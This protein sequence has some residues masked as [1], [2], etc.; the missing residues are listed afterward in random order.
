MWTLRSEISY[1]FKEKKIVEEGRGNKN[2]NSP[3]KQEKGNWGKT[4]SKSLEGDAPS[5]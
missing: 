1:L 3:K 5:D 4:T 2:L